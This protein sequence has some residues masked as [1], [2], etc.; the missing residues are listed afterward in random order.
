[1]TLNPS[2]AFLNNSFLYARVTFAAKH[3]GLAL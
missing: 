2:D 1:M 3:P